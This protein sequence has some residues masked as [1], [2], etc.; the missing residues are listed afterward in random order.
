MPAVQLARLRRQTAELAEYFYQPEVLVR[1][2]TDLFEFY[3]DRT[4]RPNQPSTAQTLIKTY[5]VPQP[6]LRRVGQELGALIGSDPQAALVLIDVLW[7]Q[8]NLESRLLAIELLGKLDPGMLSEIS[9]RALAWNQANDEG[10]LLEALGRQGMARLREESPDALLKFVDRL[11]KTGEVR[12][13]R[14]GLLALELLLEEGRFE[15][16]PAVYRSLNPA[17]KKAEKGL[18]SSLIGVIR[19]L[20]QQSPQETAFFLRQILS[21][22][23]NRTLTQIIRRSLEEFPPEFQKSLRSALKSED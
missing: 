9:E 23:K 13:Q 3:A 8:E 16:L 1:K 22:N 19:P 5:K 18:R 11:L 15:N 4:Q 2:L 6:V 12:Q 14:F 10:K 20:V 7:A 21:K 17:L